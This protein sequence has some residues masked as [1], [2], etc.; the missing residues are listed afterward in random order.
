MPAHAESWLLPWHAALTAAGPAP[1]PRPGPTGPSLPTPAGSAS[2]LARL[3][4]LAKCRYQARRLAGR[5]AALQARAHAW[6]TRRWLIHF[7][8]TYAF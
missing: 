3:A 7:L 1:V 5:L 8:R 6:Q 4:R 2:L